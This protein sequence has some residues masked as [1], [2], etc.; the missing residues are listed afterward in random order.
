[1]TPVIVPIATAFQ[2]DLIQIGVMVVLNT[3]IALITP[4][5]GLCLYIA[6]DV[7]EAPIMRVTKVL[8]PF[9]FALII[10]LMLVTFIPELTTFLPKLIKL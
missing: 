1:M 7:A 6:S 2:I 5:V 9:F 3:M 4:P 8:V 10:S